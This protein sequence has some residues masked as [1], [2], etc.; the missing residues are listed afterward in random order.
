MKRVSALKVSLSEK[1]HITSEGKLKGS[2]CPSWI[3]TGVREPLGSDY[4]RLWGPIRVGATFSVVPPAQFNY[5][6]AFLDDN[7]KF[8][9]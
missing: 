7:A 9:G 5:T 4:N 1:V 6:A 3:S 2:G 8:R